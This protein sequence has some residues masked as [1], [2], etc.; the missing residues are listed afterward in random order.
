MGPRFDPQGDKKVFLLY[1]NSIRSDYLKV[2]GVNC[3]FKTIGS[4]F[5]MFA[6]WVAIL[7]GKITKMWK[8]LSMILPALNLLRRRRYLIGMP[9]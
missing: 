1:L 9:P 5:C 2:V 6:F 4:Q 8:I 7:I 3:S